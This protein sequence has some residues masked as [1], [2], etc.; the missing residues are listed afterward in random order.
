MGRGLRRSSDFGALYR[1]ASGRLGR[2][3]L[4]SSQQPRRAHSVALA[5]PRAPPVGGNG[6]RRWTPAA[7]IS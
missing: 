6:G 5:P 2:Y 3:H 7:R 4:L 1:E